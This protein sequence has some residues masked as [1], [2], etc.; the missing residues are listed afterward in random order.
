MSEKP[1]ISH[2]ICWRCWQIAAKNL[3]KLVNIIY[4]QIGERNQTEPAVKIW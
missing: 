2:G 4:Q 3:T 1:Q